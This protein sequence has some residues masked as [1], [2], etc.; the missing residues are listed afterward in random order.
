MFIIADENMPFAAEAFSNLGEV[1]LV[2]GRD[3]KAETLRGADILAVRSV[4]RVDRALLDD[5]GVRFVGTATIGMD[6]VDRD[7]LAGRGI[8]FSSAPGCNAVSVAE[9][10]T[11]ALFVLRERL[12]FSLRGKKLGIVGV[13][14]VGSRVSQRAEALGLEVIWNDPPLAASTGDSRYRPLEEIY[15]CDIITFHVPLDK[16][17]P[18]SY[19][20]ICWM[21]TFLGRLKPGA[22]VFNTSRGAVADNV[23]LEAALDSGR[24]A[25]AVLD[26]WEGEPSVRLS[27]L[28]KAALGTPHIAG[29]HMTGKCG[30][31]A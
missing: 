21:R 24:L 30:E 13:G 5:S 28:E 17:G 22:I 19:L 20:I 29:T 26:V 12:G 27:L 25:A 8:G 4:T 15:D 9:Y 18:Y 1:R 3:M 11:A 23:A 31:R 7:W 2:P 6:H 10:V 14:N 16:S